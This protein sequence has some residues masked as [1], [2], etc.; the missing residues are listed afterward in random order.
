MTLP[1]DIVTF[2]SAESTAVPL[3]LAKRA[4]QASDLISIGADGVRQRSV[5]H[6]NGIRG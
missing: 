4:L 2:R 6:N 5:C 3:V 1:E